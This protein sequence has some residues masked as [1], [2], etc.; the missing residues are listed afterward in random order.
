MKKE[1]YTAL[2]QNIID[3]IR[4]LMTSLSQ[5]NSHIHQEEAR[6]IAQQTL[7]R[8]QNLQ[9]VVQLNLTELQQNAEWNLFTIAF[10][11]ETNAGKSTLI[12]TLRLLLNEETK[13]EEHKK[14]KENER[15]EVT[16]I[17]K[18]K[19]TGYCYK[20]LEKEKQDYLSLFNN[21]YQ[22]IASS[23][24][25]Q[26]QELTSNIHELQEY[27]TGKNI[28]N[29]PLSTIFQYHRKKKELPLLT[30]QLQALQ[31]KNK[32]TLQKLQEQNIQKSASFQSKLQALANEQQYW[33]QQK[34]KTEKGL[35]M[36]CDGNIIGDGRSDFT[37]KTHSYTFWIDKHPFRL[38]DLPGIEGAEDLVKDEIRSSLQRCHAVFYISSKNTPPQHGEDGQEGAIEK[39]ASQLNAQAEIY[40]VYNKRITS[41]AFLTDELETS[42][43]K[44]ALTEL[45]QRMK[46]T[47]SDRYKKH[48][49]VS[50]QPAF[51]SVAEKAYMTPGNNF[52]KQQEK[53][54][55]RFSTDEL[56]EKSQLN[57]FV[58][59]LENI[60][61]VAKIEKAN[62]YQIF[63]LLTEA[64]KIAAALQKQ[65]KSI[66]RKVD[67]EISIA[68]IKLKENQSF[69]CNT[70]QAASAELV[71]NMINTCRA[72][73]YKRIDEGIS[74]K[75]LEENVNSLCTRRIKQ[76]NIDL[77]RHN[78]KATVELEKRQKAVL[79]RLNER[80]SEFTEV[81]L[82]K[83]VFS[84]FNN[85]KIPSKLT[86]GKICQ[87][88]GEFLLLSSAAGVITTAIKAGAIG[89]SAG[90]PGGGLLAVAVTVA[91]V[92]LFRIGKMIWNTVH[93]KD[94]QKKHISQHL[95][96]IK[97]QVQQELH[98]WQKN[99]E[100][101][102]E[103]VTKQLDEHLDEINQSYTKQQK[104][105]K[106]FINA[107]DTMQNNTLQKELL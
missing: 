90:G 95:D 101:D 79:L 24:H 4:D 16:Q 40:S 81:L 28:W 22:K 10:Y 17:Q 83:N 94:H 34:I 74:N 97:K 21:Q 67:S 87:G 41:P 8:L 103:K 11:G 58:R 59:A 29:I 78:K 104:Y 1:T 20:Q 60:I 35:Q 85:F 13:I 39:I 107:L 92:G 55:K 105:I 89:T 6:R 51:L 61:H 47:L 91:I 49:S 62:R 68:K 65:F 80:V 63:A 12:E 106:D 38:L 84:T 31:A 50:A 48:F 57:A 100:I 69:Y 45:Q 37:R 88:T 77:Q 54:L 25:K 82:S 96:K 72:E 19:H 9:K 102:I 15:L 26:E 23:L 2:Y 99:N 73:L 71:Q 75:D 3:Q 27:L 18:L 30:A 66:S 93:K 33:E 43:D 42:D 53:F 44:T 98:L 56:R 70:L 14:Y 64:K 5:E 7:T 32:G 76:L 52:L 46:E 86:W 36:L